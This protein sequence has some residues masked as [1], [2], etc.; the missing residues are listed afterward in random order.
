VLL[1][2]FGPVRWTMYPDSY[3][4][5]RAAERILGASPEEAH[6]TALVAFCTDRPGPGCLDRWRD[7]QD[8]TTADPR[9]QAIFAGR[10]GYP[11]VAAP[12]VA[13]LGVRAGL[14][15]LGVLMALTG[16]LLVVGLLRAAGLGPWPRTVGQIAFLAC[17]LGWWATQALGEGLFT[18]CTLGAVWGGVLLL[19]ARHVGPAA[20]ATTLALAAGAITRYSSVLLLSALLAVAALAAYCASPRWRHRGALVLVGLSAAAAAA[21]GAAIAA[22][23]LPSASTTLQDTFTH[24]F[25]TPDVADP[26]HA[27]ARLAAQY[28]SGWLAGQAAAPAF[29]VLTAVAAAAL[30]GSRTPLGP[31]ALACALTGAGTVTAHPLVQEADRLGVL[32]WIPV[33][34]GLPVLAAHAGALF[35]SRDTRATT[36]NPVSPA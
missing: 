6:R 2:L 5:A 17:P 35:R 8:I 24:H 33:V 29:L 10:P 18:V 15:A 4:Y 32:L 28:W 12:F 22:L 36:V 16:S 27:L 31:L 23:G 20:A 11:L 13:A 19:R 30:V 25:E 26:W 7:A 3:R 14:R 34:L 21:T 9:Y 1:Q